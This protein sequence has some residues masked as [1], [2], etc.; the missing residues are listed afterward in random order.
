MGV[1][2]TPSVLSQGYE[3]LMQMFHHPSF[4]HSP[5]LGSLELSEME[6]MVLLPLVVV[7]PRNTL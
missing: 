5:V 7:L 1:N 2:F 4:F 3:P 6:S